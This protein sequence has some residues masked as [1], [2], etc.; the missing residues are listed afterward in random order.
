MRPTKLTSALDGIEY[1][2][3]CDEFG[4]CRVVRGPMQ[5]NTSSKTF[6]G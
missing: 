5:L 2:R 3:I 6:Q 1:Y 4:I